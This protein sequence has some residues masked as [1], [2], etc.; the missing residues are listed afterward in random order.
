M[1]QNNLHRDEAAARAALLTVQSYDVELDLTDGQGGPRGRLV[2][3]QVVLAHGASDPSSRAGGG[4]LAT[5][6]ASA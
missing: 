5:A 2:A 6:D 3:V 1:S 4:H